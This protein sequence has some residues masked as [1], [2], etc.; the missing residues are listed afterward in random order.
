MVKFNCVNH[1]LI[2]STVKCLFLCLKKHQHKQ[3]GVCRT[4]FEVNYQTGKYKWASYDGRTHGGTPDSQ[5]KN[6]CS[7]GFLFQVPAND[8]PSMYQISKEQIL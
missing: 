6:G 1:W 4:K 2:I 7:L 3:P 5:N 8:R